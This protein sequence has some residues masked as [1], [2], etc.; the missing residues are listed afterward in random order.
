LFYSVRVIVDEKSA[1]I[2]HMTEQRSGR[3]VPLEE[4]SSQTTWHLM[5]L[6]GV[7]EAENKDDAIQQAQSQVIAV[8]EQAAKQIEMYRMNVL[9]GLAVSDYVPA[10]NYL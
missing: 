3:A 8:I 2:I 4:K 7:I 10:R 5:A 1:E 9:K 6:E